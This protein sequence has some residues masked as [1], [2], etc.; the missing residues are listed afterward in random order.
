MLALFMAPG[1]LDKKAID[2]IKE[3]KNLVKFEKLKF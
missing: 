2:F 3:Y 1:E